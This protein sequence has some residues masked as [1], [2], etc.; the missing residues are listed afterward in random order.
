M[1]IVNI[2]GGILLLTLGRKLFWLSV[3]ATGFFAGF[4]LA[5]RLL[6]TTEGWAALV[7]G[8]LVGVVGALL[9]YF[10]QKV[11]IGAVGFFAGAYLGSRLVPQLGTQVQG[12]E[13]LI[14][15][16]GGVIGIFL[17]FIIFD[18][19]LII[20]S[21]LAGAALVV[22]GFNLTG[23]VAL[24]LGVLLV[25]VGMVFQF[26]LNRRAGTTEKVAS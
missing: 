26:G 1:S 11:A 24:F 21:S 4:E 8:I 17:M 2:V 7:I 23:L 3:A 14:V 12:W 20:L 9:V 6:G 13:W 10:F 18:W 16:M 15:L 22:E 25:I 5:T 19:A